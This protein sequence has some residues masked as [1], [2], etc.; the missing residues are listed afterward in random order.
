MIEIK[1]KNETLN[2]IEIPEWVIT[3]NLCSNG[4]QSYFRD[5]RNGTWFYSERFE[6]G[7]Y[8]ILGEVNK[9]D[10]AYYFI[11]MMQG[12]ELAEGNK[13]IVLKAKSHES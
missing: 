5:L 6:R 9:N 7:K 1:T 2:L 13:Y 8:L 4:N 3:D 12:I 11:Q 10:I